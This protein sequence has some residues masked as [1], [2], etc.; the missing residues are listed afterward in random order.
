M[1]GG[2]LLDFY[3]IRLIPSNCSYSSG[4]VLVAVALV[5]DSILHLNNMSTIIIKD[6]NKRL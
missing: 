6:S 1:G 2:L 4:L 5:A 3:G